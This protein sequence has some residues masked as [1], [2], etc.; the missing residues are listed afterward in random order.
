MS[1]TL[2]VFNEDKFIDSKDEHFWNIRL[3]LVTL[4]VLNEDNLW[5][6]KMNNN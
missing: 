4:F 1:I 2:F 5:I 6:S 3:M